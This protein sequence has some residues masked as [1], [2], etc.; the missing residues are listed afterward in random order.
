MAMWVKKYISDKWKLSWFEL[1][2]SQN[3]KWVKFLTLK[4]QWDTNW[5]QLSWKFSSHAEMNTYNTLQRQYMK[6]GLTIPHNIEFLTNIFF[7]YYI[8]RAYKN[9]RLLNR[10]ILLKNMKEYNFSWEFLNNFGILEH[11]WKNRKYRKSEGFVSIVFKNVL[12]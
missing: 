5:I 4:V 3:Q 11:F 6:N 2:K 7:E 10:H 12:K 1:W 8:E 9:A